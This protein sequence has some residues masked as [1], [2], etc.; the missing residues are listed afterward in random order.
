[1]PSWRVSE[2]LPGRLGAFDLVIMDE[3][4]Q[5]DIRELPA[6]LRGK[7]ILVVGDDKQVSPT[8]AFIETAKLDRL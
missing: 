4:S 5:S 2:Q 3:A 1:M 8:A 7:K 6:L